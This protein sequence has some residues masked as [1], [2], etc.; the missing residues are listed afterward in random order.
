MNSMKITQ[1][2]QYY[3]Y[4]GGTSFDPNSP[5]LSTNHKE[6]EKSFA[7]PQVARGGLLSA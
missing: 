6:K 7:P 1:G 3:K 5:S 4:L 2:R